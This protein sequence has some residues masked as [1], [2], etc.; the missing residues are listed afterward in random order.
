[1]VENP[2]PTKYSW[3]YL[4]LAADGLLNVVAGYGL[5]GIKLILQGNVFNK[6]G[7]LPNMLGLIIYAIEQ[8]VL[9]GDGTLLSQILRVITA[10]NPA[11]SR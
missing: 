11:T 2:L 1:M 4:T 7:K 3:K 6:T 9:D 10:G 8:G 5:K